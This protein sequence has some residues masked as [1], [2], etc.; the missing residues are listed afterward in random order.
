[1][2][3]ETVHHRWQKNLK[4]TPKTFEFTQFESC[5]GIFKFEEDMHELITWSK[6]EIVILSPELNGFMGAKEGFEGLF[7]MKDLRSLSTTWESLSSN[8]GKRYS[9]HGWPTVVAS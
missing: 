2:G 9:C 4:N 6:D 8:W 5:E 3:F 1:M 7:D